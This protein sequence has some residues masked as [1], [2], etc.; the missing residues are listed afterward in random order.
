MNE[1]IQ[2]R[3]QAPAQAPAEDQTQQQAAAIPDA[4]LKI[5]AVQATLAGTP[6]A[7]SVNLKEFDKRPEAKV[8]G[9]NIQ[10][11]MDAGF[12]TYRSL[13][14]DTGVLYNRFFMADQE[15]KQADE[16]GQLQ[17]VAPSF[18]DLNKSVAASGEKHPLLNAG[19][20]P[21]GFKQ[22]QPPAATSMPSGAPIQA[23]DPKAQAARAK[24]AMPGSPTSGPKPGA[25]RILN[26]ILRP[27]I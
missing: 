7:F 16:A 18:D 25:G 3:E 12:G 17:T 4:V 10:P 1:V 5:P 22:M 27:V 8:L 23:T 9:E 6:A 15:L 2:P 19:E 24:N 13:S 14:G 26:S 11:L 21:G 20:R